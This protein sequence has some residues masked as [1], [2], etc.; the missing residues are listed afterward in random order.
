MPFSHIPHLQHNLS[1][2]IPSEFSYIWLIPQLASIITIHPTTLSLLH[3]LFP[4]H[5]HEIIHIPIIFFFRINPTLLL[6]YT[7]C[8]PQHPHADDTHPPLYEPTLS[9]KPTNSISITPP[10]RLL[11]PLSSQTSSCTFLV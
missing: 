4:Y 2:H 7:P 8:I 5:L 11:V 9:S 3:R 1:H 6:D 10:T